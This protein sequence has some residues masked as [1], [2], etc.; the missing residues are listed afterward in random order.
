MLHTQSLGGALQL[1]PILAMIAGDGAFE[2]DASAGRPEAILGDAGVSTH[3]E[4]IEPYTGQRRKGVRTH[5][6]AGGLA[7]QVS[8]SF[9]VLPGTMAPQPHQPESQEHRRALA[10]QSH[11]RGR[12]SRREKRTREQQ[13]E[14]PQQRD[15]MLSLEGGGRLASKGG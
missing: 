8:G 14:L 9:C 10:S 12:F 3:L 1:E 5:S 15:E 13:K 6:S 7:S 2:E 4:V 11:D